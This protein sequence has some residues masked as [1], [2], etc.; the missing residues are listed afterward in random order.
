MIRRFLTRH[1]HIILY[2]LSLALLLILL[3]WLEWR[4]IVIDRAIEIYSGAIAVVFTGLGIW[5]ALKLARPKEK[6]VIVEKEVYVTRETAMG[7]PIDEKELARL[8]ISPRELEVLQLMAGGLS[9]QEI[10]ARLFVSLNTI[11]T[12]TGNIFVKLDVRRRTQAVE[13]A[14]KL[15][16]IH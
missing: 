12:H 10:A 16:L 8:G 11:K 4:F 13:Q 6:T 7:T 3:K 1:R 14:R 2:G 9:N 5:L 15:N